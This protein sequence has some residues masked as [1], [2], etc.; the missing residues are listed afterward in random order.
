MRKKG[1][2]A[3]EFLMTYGWAILVVLIAIGALAYFGVLK[4]EKFLP[5]K[6]VISTGSGLFCDEFT[7]SSSANTVTLRI[8]NIL[9]ESAWV[10][11]VALD[12]PAC[13]FST[14]DTQ[15]TADST[16]DFSLSCAG[17]LTSGDKIKGTI[18]V[19]YDTGATAGS[20][21]SKTTTGQLVAV[22]P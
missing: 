2:A 22:V 5:E 14:A 3:M 15:I 4:P 7:S 1:Q 12:A 19:T 18:T 16:T 17:G 10:D 8:K 11:S 20:G 21:L 13:T 6:C 9:T